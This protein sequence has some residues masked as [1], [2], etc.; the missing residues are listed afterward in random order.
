MYIEEDCLLMHP[1]V[2]D[3]DGTLIHTDMLHE[4][5]LRILR[6]SPLDTLRIPF[7]LSKGKAVLKQHLAARTEFDPTSLPYNGE[8][9]DWLR[10]QKSGGRKL[11]LCTASDKS[12]ALSIAD[13]LDIFDEVI[14]SDGLTNLAGKHKAAALEQR[15]GRSGFDY[16]GNS[17][18]D[19]AVWACARRAVIVNASNELAKKAGDVCQ[20]EQI[21]HPRALG[22]SAW[23][24]VLRVHQWL[25]NLLLFVPIFAAHQ[26]TSADAWTSLILAFF[27]FSLCASSV[28]IVNDLLDLESDRQ[29]PR[30]QNRP[31][32][33]GQVPAWLGVA[34]SPVL[35]I[36][37]LGLGVVCR[38]GVFAMASVLFCSYL[39]VFLESETRNVSGLSRLGNPLYLPHYRWSSSGRS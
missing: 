2:V 25:K 26:L 9:L 12:I 27:S 17:I 16:A 22:F 19:L 15:F 4:S 21:F 6:D 39:C 38:R 34:L 7:W 36:A 1:L 24:R 18:A 37:S 23:L 31:F 5:A 11:I 13:H 10:Q 14:A 35:L 29:H 28:Y 3:L 20:V 32:A 33:S 8:L 30:K